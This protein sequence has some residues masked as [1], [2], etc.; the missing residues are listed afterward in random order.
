MGKGV[1]GGRITSYSFGSLSLKYNIE[2]VK[3]EVFP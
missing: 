2:D 1:S 3:M